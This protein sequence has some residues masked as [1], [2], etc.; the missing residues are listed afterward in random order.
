ML[1][2]LFSPAIFYQIPT[3]NQT[4]GACFALGISKAYAIN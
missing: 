3:E 4:R 2:L 1:Y